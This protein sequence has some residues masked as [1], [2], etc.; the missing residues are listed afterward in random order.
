M[1]VHLRQMNKLVD[2]TVLISPRALKRL[3]PA[4]FLID[5]MVLY[6][7]YYYYKFPPV[8]GAEVIIVAFL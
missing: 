8:R 1:S 4:V 5:N 7:Y 2:R 3:Q 6:Y